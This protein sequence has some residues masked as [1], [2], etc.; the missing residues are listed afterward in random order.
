[1][2]DESKEKFFGELEASYVKVHAE[3]HKKSDKII[4]RN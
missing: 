2:K 3:L 1:M 4:N